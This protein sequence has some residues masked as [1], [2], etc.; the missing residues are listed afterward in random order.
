[1]NEA[2][3][4]YLRVREKEGRLYPDLLAR[5]LPAIP[6][7]HPLYKEWRARAASSDRLTS[8]LARLGYPLTILDLGCG[9]GWLANRIVKSAGNASVVGVDLNLPELTQARRLFQDIARLSWIAA[10]ISSAPF[11]QRPFDVIVMASSIQYFPDLAALLQL[12]LPLLKQ[13]GEIHFLD[14]P[15]YSSEEVSSARDRTRKYYENLGLPEMAAHYHH[16]SVA[17]LDAYDPVWLYSPQA[18][19]VPDSPFPW[20][21][22]RPEMVR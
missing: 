7:G 11:S 16:H 14:S 8:Y 2:I 21:R 6:H 20:I 19:K 9:N 10:D 22:L 12:L 17:L 18:A 4:T 5:E 1:M 15:F 3:H 13:N